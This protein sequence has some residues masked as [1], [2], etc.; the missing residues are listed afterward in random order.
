[1]QFLCLSTSDT[2][3]KLVFT[4]ERFTSAAVTINYGRCD[5]EFS[6]C[7]IGEETKAR[8]IICGD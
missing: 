5:S 6:V 4:V 3:Y 2:G 8:G 7:N 1:M